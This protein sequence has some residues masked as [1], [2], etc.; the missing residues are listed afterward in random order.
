MRNRRHILQDPGYGI[1]VGTCSVKIPY[2][3]KW[4]GLIRSD[5]HDHILTMLKLVHTPPDVAYMSS[6]GRVP[7]RCDDTPKVLLSMILRSLTLFI[8]LLTRKR[9]GSIRHTYRTPCIGASV[10][11]KATPS[12]FLVAPGL[13]LAWALRCRRLRHQDE[14]QPFHSI[15]DERSVEAIFPHH[16]KDSRE[17]Y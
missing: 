15:V 11:K 16:M 13:C 8:S 12:S 5:V 9:I 10:A 1:V 17:D 2:A 7:N 14:T 3:M 6:R 4:E